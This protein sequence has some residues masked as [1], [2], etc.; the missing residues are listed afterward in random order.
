MLEYDKIR[1]QRNRF[2]ALTGLTD[3]EFQALLPYFRDANQAL[4][5]PNKTKLGKKR[6]RNQGGGRKSKLSKV[7]DQLLFILVYQ[8]N[9]PVQE[10]LAQT[11]GVSLSSVNTWIHHYLPILKKSLDNMGVMPERNGKK[12]AQRQAAKNKATQTLVIDGTERRIQRPVDAEQQRQQYSGKKK[13]HTD[14]NIVVTELKSKEVVFLSATYVGKSHD[15]AIAD[16]EG[17]VYPKQASLYQDT[18]FQGYAPK[19]KAVLQPKKNHAR[20]N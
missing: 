5:K 14:K 13:G 6:K 10:L 7:E 12:L 20:R 16:N 1:E 3:T 4:T 19:V 18:G 9:Y 17:V 15:K 11:Y 8:K 2:L